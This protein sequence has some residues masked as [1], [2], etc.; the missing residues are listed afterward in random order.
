MLD[1]LN[2]VVTVDVVPLHD[3]LFADPIDYNVSA[4]LG[5][6]SEGTIRALDIMLSLILLL[7]LLPVFILTIAAVIIEDPGPIF[8]SHMRVGR[9]GESFGCLKFRSMIVGAEKRLVEILDRDPALQ[10]E[11]IANRKLR[12]DPRVTKIGAVLRRTSVDEIPQLINVLRGDMSLIG[13]RPIVEEEMSL[14]GRYFREYA[15]VRPGISGLWQISGRSDISY[16]RRI[17]LDVVYARQRSLGLYL[18]ILWR[19]PF[20]VLSTKGC[21]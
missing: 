4:V 18:R 21:Y 17:A 9:G 7:I 12:R 2:D 19:T 15:T 10:A 8:F 14:Y 16:R 3:N 1:G 13:P 11:W 20:C 5:K 6:V